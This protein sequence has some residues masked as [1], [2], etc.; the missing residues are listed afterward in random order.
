MLQIAPLT[1]A[2]LILCCLLALAGLICTILERRGIL[3][4]ITQRTGNRIRHFSGGALVL[5]AG[6]LGINLLLPYWPYSLRYCIAYALVLAA[7]YFS[8]RLLVPKK[9]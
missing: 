1:L 6:V 2:K 8:I 9:D 7:A 3:K 4:P 5:V